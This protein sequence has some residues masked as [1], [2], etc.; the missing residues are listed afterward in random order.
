MVPYS[1]GEGPPSFDIPAGACDCHM[2]LFDTRYPFAGKTALTHGEATAGDYQKLKRRLGTSRC[3][4]VQPSGYGLDHRA[5]VGGLNAL[6]DSSRGVAVVTPDAADHELDLFSAS[7]IVG[8]RFNLVQRGATDESMLEAVAARAKPL[9]WHIQLHLR[10]ADLVR[11][12]DRLS[13]LPV[14]VVLD[15]FARIGTN[16]APPK[17]VYAQ[18]YRLMDTGNVWLKLSAPYIA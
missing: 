7:G 15:H 6:G 12:A 10:S 11:L 3:V 13:Q 4:V 9:G 1:T 18:L 5:L 8:T 16:E 14:P 17:R 2:H